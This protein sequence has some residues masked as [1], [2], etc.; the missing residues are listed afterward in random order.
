MENRETEETRAAAISVSLAGA[1]FRGRRLIKFDKAP[2]SIITT[3]VEIKIY[4]RNKNYIVAL[5]YIFDARH[6]N[7]IAR[8]SRALAGK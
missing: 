2:C 3:K 1:S 6:A 5:C 7:R 8:E 4:D